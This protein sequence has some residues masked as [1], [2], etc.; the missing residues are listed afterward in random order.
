MNKDAWEREYKHS[1][2]LTKKFEPQA[3]VI[4]FFKFLKKDQHIQ[5]E[6]KTLLDLGCGTGRNSF[7]AHELGYTV[8]G[9]DIS[10]HAI[11][12]GLAHAKEIGVD[13]DLHYGSIGEPLLYE[14]QTFDCALDITSSN[15]LTSDERD[16]YVREMNRVLKKGGF[17]CVKA[18]CKEGDTNAKALLEKFPGKE[19]DTYILP[20]QG[21][22][23]RVW[24]KKDF[25]DFY[26]KYFSI[27]SLETKDSYMTMGERMY[28][29]KF[30][31]L[32]L[33]K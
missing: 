33:Q 17:A 31:I 32:Y 20:E 23:E 5:H 14:D 7:Y 8:H 11:S 12:L 1:T 26:S 10:K 18:L 4:R 21:I 15:S 13:I 2:F 3:D 19:K 28:K 29:R 24:T 25:I 27:V 6:G 9:I 16:V 22:I 30:F